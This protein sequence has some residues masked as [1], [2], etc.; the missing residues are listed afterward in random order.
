[1]EKKQKNHQTLS[2][3]VLKSLYTP[4]DLPDFNYDEKLGMPG[5]YPFTRG[6]TPE[7]YRDNLWI[8]GQYSGF[9]TAEEAN[10]RYRYLIE[11]GQTG[12]SIALDLPTQMGYDSDSIKAEGEVGKVGVAI[13]SLADIET[14]FNGIQLEQVRQIRTTANANSLIMMALYVAFARKNNIDPNNI[15]FYRHHIDLLRFDSQPWEGR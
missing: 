10:K 3:V 4:Q 2:G 6:I 7:M 1:M 13:D 8:M 5:S 11:Q 15:R 12:F 14:L 9:S